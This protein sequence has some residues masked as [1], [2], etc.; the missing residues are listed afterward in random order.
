MVEKEPVMNLEKRKVLIWI[1]LLACLIL[2][3]MINLSAGGCSKNKD[4]SAANA[5]V[6]D[7]GASS[8]DGGVTNFTEVGEDVRDL[9]CAT[10]EGTGV[11]IRKIELEAGKRDSARITIS[12]PEHTDAQAV[13]AGFRILRDNFPKL[14]SYVVKASGREYE[15]DGQVLAYVASKG[16]MIDITEE[17]A[18]EYMTIV[19]NGIPVEDVGKPIR[20]EAI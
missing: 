4:N 16:W 9:I 19:K 7:S 5:A 12:F 6:I 2:L 20:V 8:D 18:E 15:C 3:V 17:V 14:K 11:D 1:G 13:L 10:Y